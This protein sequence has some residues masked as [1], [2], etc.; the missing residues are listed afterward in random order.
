MESFKTTSLFVLSLL[1]EKSGF[2]IP[3]S[4]KPT[5]KVTIA[6]TIITSLGLLV[7][8]FLGRRSVG[9]IRPIIKRIG[10]PIIMKMPTIIPRIVLMR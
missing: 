1:E 4:N 7:F 9:L 2:S 8:T 5:I 3:I 10:K 6:V